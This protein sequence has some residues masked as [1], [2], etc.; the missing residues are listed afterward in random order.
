MNPNQSPA[1]QTSMQTTQG[2]AYAAATDSA[3]A[4]EYSALENPLVLAARAFECQGTLVLAVL[5]EPI[6]LSSERA[7]LKNLLESAAV[8]STGKNVVV[9]FDLEIY[10]RISRD[11]PDELKSLLLR[12]ATK[13]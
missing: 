13:N 10:R 3:L 2:T 8:A 6:F 4:A 7:E 5:T 12:K 9:S 11:M 1:V